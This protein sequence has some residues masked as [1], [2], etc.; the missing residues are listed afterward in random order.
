MLQEKA[1]L[2]RAMLSKKKAK[3]AVNPCVACPATGF[4]TGSAEYAAYA[5]KE[6]VWVAAKPN[7]KPPKVVNTTAGN[8]LP[9]KNSRMP[10]RN[11]RMVPQP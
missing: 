4:P 7:Q 5:P 11:M 10:P 3:L 1:V 8:V 2:T 9:R 6:G